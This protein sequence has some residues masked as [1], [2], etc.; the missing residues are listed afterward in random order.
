MKL[1]DFQKYDLRRLITRLSTRDYL[2]Q[3]K[4]CT[5]RGLPL[6]NTLNS[7][8]GFQSSRWMLVR[9]CCF[10]GC[11]MY[12]AAPVAKSILKDRRL[13]HIYIRIPPAKCVKGNRRGESR[14]REAIRQRQHPRAAN[15]HCRTMSNYIV[16]IAKA[17]VRQY[18]RSVATG[19]MRRSCAEMTASSF[20]K[21][22]P[23][24]ETSML[25][26]SRFHTSCTRYAASEC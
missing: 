23:G 8:A 7:Q 4:T 22:F 2:I 14:R 3:R 25:V 21:S 11:L 26:T 1:Y 18:N 24:E 20:F 17:N 5:R 12:T 15:I 9:R 13:I 19:M 16:A 10:T 6:E